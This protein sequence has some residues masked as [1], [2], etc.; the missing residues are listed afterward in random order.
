MKNHGKMEMTIW[1]EQGL[2]NV[3]IEHHPTTGDIITHRYMK[4]MFKITK[5]GHLPIPAERYMDKNHDHKYDG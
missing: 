4:V 3:L 1:T 2:V 5:K